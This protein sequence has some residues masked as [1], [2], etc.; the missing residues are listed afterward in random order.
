MP[1]LR[2]RRDDIPMLVRAFLQEGA[3][4]N[5]KP[6]REIS[7]E[8]MACLLN[9]DWP[10]NVRELKTAIEH[11][12]VMATGAKIG[13]RDLPILVSGQSTHSLLA[14]QLASSATTPAN[15]AL[16]LQQT[17]LALIMRALE[18]SHGNRTEAAERLG[19][20]RRTLHRRLKELHIKKN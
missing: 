12:V 3:E 17:E 11:G 9:Y 20:S 6:F 4:E 5:G 14:G 7:T 18:E 15:Q 16:N 2:E 8:A 10:G 19:I 1:P 13:V